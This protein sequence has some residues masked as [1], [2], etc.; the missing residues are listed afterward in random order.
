[1]Y[2]V[3]RNYRNAKPLFDEL[4]KRQPEIE[5]LLRGVNGFSAYYLVRTS[6][7]G[8]T[9]TI[10]RDQTGTKE[11]TRLAAE[12]IR[13]NVSSVAGSPPEITEGEV[14]FSF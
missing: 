11:S 14:L 2:A 3:V 13:Q 7:G 9:I 4:A 1:M 10:C 6:D 5:S 8:A 12:W